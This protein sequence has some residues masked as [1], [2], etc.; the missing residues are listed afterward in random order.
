MGKIPIRSEIVGVD[1]EKV[2]Y[3]LDDD[4]FDVVAPMPL[5]V[6]VEFGASFDG[7]SKQNHST[8]RFLYGP[9]AWASVGEVAVWKQRHI[10]ANSAH[11]VGL[12]IVQVVDD[13]PRHIDEQRGTPTVAHR[14]NPANVRSRSTAVAGTNHRVHAHSLGAPRMSGLDR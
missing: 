7:E 3:R 1:V 6:A 13:V 2:S 14:R 12:N 4:G 11:Q 9:L 5:I 8:F 10:D